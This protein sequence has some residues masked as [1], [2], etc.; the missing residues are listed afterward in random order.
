MLLSP[1]CRLLASFLPSS[2]VGR[3]S[4]ASVAAITVWRDA[5]R[6]HLWKRRRAVGRRSTSTSSTGAT[7]SRTSVSDDE[8]SAKRE[9]SRTVSS[10]YNQVAIDEAAAKVVHEEGPLSIVMM[11]KAIYR[12]SLLFEKLEVHSPYSINNHVHGSRDGWH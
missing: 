10:Y 11:C 7:S 2:P 3:S 4:I 5:S 1:P 9:R 12:L 6:S 8:R